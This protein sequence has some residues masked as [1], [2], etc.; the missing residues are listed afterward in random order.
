MNAG[1]T[2]FRLWTTRKVVSRPTF[3]GCV[4]VAPDQKLVPRRL[5]TDQRRPSKKGS[6][7]PEQMDKCL[8]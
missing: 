6:L 5:G 2:I 1:F 8:D 3:E 4:T 7:G